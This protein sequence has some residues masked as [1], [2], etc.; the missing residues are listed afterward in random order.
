MNKTALPPKNSKLLY[1]TYIYNTIMI[2]RDIVPK[3]I[4]NKEY[5]VPSCLMSCLNTFPIA[6]ILA[7]K[8]E[9]TCGL[10]DMFELYTKNID[11]EIEL[12]IDLLS[13]LFPNHQYAR[14]PYW[15][16]N[17]SDHETGVSMLLT[18]QVAQYDSVMTEARKL[19]MKK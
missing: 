15:P 9:E 12:K 11:E 4:G 7:D 6:F 19:K 10:Y 14:H 18:S 2:V 17:V 8:C 5:D 13:Y 3:K 16:C 1:Y